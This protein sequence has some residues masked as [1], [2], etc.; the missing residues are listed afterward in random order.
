MKWDVGEHFHRLFSLND[1][2]K[3]ICLQVWGLS[4]AWKFHVWLPLVLAKCS[5]GG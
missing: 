4:W 5:I 3:Q 1:R 2:R